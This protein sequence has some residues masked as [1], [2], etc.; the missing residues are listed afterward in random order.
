MAKTILVLHG[1]T[2]RKIDTLSWWHNIV[3]NPK[4]TMQRRT[5]ALTQLNK[6]LG[7]TATVT[8]QDIEDYIIASNI[9]TS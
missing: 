6:N 7:D 2:S 4:N 9:Q 5:L 1:Q 8:P 3:L